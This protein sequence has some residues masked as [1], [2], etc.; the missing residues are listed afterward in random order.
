M[1]TWRLGGLYFFTARCAKGKNARDAGIFAEYSPY[2]FS[3]KTWPAL[4]VTLLLPMCVAA[5]SADDS[6]RSRQCSALRE[7]LYQ[8]GQRYSGIQDVRLRG[9]EGFRP[10]GT[11]RFSNEHYSTTLPWV[12]AR[13]T[14]LEHSTDQRDSTSSDS[15]QYMAWFAETADAVAANTTFVQIVRQINGCVLPLNDTM[16]ITLAPVP[17]EQLPA[18]RPDDDWLAAYLADCGTA[19]EAK[20]ALMVGLERTRRGYRPTLILEWLLE[21]RR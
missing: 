20:L 2:L 12:G 7:L 11:W 6:L 21:R 1:S 5:Q 8:A 13:Q 18:L 17:A 16:T 4:L 19:G 9:S 15:W 3:M 14:R 10:N